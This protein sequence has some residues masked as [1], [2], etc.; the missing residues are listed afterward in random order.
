M[1]F[2]AMVFFFPPRW[3]TAEFVVNNCV[4]CCSC[5]ERLFL[6]STI[7]YSSFF[8]NCFSAEKRT[9]CTCGCISACLCVCEYSFLSFFVC[10]TEY[11]RVY[12]NFLIC[13]LWMETCGVNFQQQNNTRSPHSPLLYSSTPL[14]FCINFA[15]SLLFLVFFCSFFFL[16][17]GI[18][19]HAFSSTSTNVCD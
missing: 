11:P 18:S 8:L 16:S 3:Y 2:W 9:R 10:C 14:M 17:G 4:C 12:M 19:A 5:T 1:G 7:L 6:F 13:L 15:L